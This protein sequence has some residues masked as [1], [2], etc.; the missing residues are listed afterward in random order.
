M[1]AF[2]Y[3]LSKR[4]YGTEYENIFRKDSK[5]ILK[6]NPVSEQC[7]ICLKRNKST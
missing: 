1:T 5:S 6:L 3:W 4:H 2:V 7:N